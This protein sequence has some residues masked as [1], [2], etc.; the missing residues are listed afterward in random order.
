MRSKA[1]VLT[2]RLPWPLD[3]GG[4]I[5]LWQTVWS[6]A[7]EYDTT[8][9]SLVAPGSEQS[10][11]PDA[12]RDLG[13]DVSR[14]PHRPPPLPLAAWRGIAGRWPYTLARYRNRT[15]ART[16]A[17]L[18]SRIH[19]SFFFVNHLHLATYVNSM[20]GIPMVLREHN[21]EYRWMA[22]YAEGLPPGPR[23]FY[24]EIQTGRLRH[25]EIEL[26]NRAALVLAIQEDEARLLNRV[27]PSALIET[28]PVG[29]D[30]SRFG[31]PNPEEPPVVLLAGAFNW[32]PN[33]DGAIRFLT[34]G[35]PRVARRFP[36]ARLRIA[37]KEPPPALF[38]A[39]HRAGVE[40]TGYVESMHSEF[41]RAA[42]MLVPLW[43]GAGARVKIIEAMAAGLPIVSTSMG[44][45]GLG[46]RAGEDFLMAD[47]PVDLGDHVITLLES[48]ERRLA[49]SEIGR[50]I[51]EA[52][53]SLET[54]AKLQNRYCAEVA[55]TGS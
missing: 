40:V 54:V 9:V 5:G 26:C 43:V 33:V 35:W 44:S 13:I 39:A 36:D 19:P 15:L 1:V 50:A 37:G 46:L 7:Q 14:I 2:P 8:L 55:R 28:V 20:A 31:Q 23:R 49:M 42:V 30:L 47:S 6:V 45:E 25:A 12:I 27:A 41:A 53:W 16:V 21:V 4:L 29:I 17:D 3:D 48:K 18:A 11:L 22:R 10:P 24:A 34:E 32:V 38:Q 52:K 51:A